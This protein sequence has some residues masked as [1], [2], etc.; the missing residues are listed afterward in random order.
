M[1]LKIIYD[2]LLRACSLNASSSPG[3]INIKLVLFLERYSMFLKLL[4]F[5]KNMEK[6]HLQGGTILLI[7]TTST[8]T[9]N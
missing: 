6:Q 3:E 7:A 4:N 5:V 9:E 1:L 8:T 2:R